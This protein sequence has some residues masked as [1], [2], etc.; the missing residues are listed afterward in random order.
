MRIALVQT[1]PVRGDVAANLARHAELLEGALALGAELVVFPELSLTGYE[2]ELAAE[3]ATAADDPRFDA[4]QRT[5]DARG[6]TIALGAP[7]RAPPKPHIGLV[8]LQPR[9]RRHVYAKR[10]LHADEEP[11]F[12]PGALSD[13]L[14][15][16]APRVALAICY[17]LSVPAHAEAALAAGV[18]VYLASAAKSAQGVEQTAARLSTLAREHGLATL[19]ANSVGAAG[20]FECAGG[21]AAWNRRGELVARL[22]DARE[23]LLVFDTASEEVVRSGS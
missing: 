6:V 8:L 10:Y 11:Y 4:L 7:I 13:G 12:T 3:L 2:P 21:T 22:G 5:S 1:R 23:G 15:G 20:G 19:L 18:G 14:L 9:E 16:T 17:E